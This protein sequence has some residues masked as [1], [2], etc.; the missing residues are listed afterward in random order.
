IE[1]GKDEVR[2]HIGRISKRSL[3]SSI[4]QFVPPH[5]R[6]SASRVFPDKAQ[7]SQISQ[8]TIDNHGTSGHERKAKKTLPVLHFTKKQKEEK[9]ENIIM[10][11]LEPSFAAFIV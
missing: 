6:S 2:I 3:E 7:S 5:R 10:N 8:N 11:H 4:D 9:E 1:H